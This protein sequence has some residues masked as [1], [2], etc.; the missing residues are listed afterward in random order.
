MISKIDD[1]SQ[2]FKSLDCKSIIHSLVLGNRSCCHGIGSKT[3][4]LNLAIVLDE[5]F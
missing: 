2:G 1:Y 5:L 3:E 4:I